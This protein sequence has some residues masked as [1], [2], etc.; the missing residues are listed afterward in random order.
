MRVDF[1]G[2]VKARLEDSEFAGSVAATTITATSVA[3]TGSVGYATGAGGA[4]TQATSKATGVTLSKICGSIT[5]HD[6][7][8]AAAAEVSFTVT[9]TLV[10]ATDVVVACIKSGATAGA[11][12][13]TVDAVAA[14]SF[15]VSIGNVSA[16]ALSEALVLNFAVIKSVA[17]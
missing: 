11:Y 3:A 10:A 13:V 4:V 2:K 9:N 12:V 15:R 7:E 8:L 6:A 5:T 14:G 1:P 16:G 17:A